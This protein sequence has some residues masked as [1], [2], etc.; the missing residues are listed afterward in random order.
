MN[1]SNYLM[2]LMLVNP[3]AKAPKVM[4]TGFLE[5]SIGGIGAV[6]NRSE[7]E[8]FSDAAMEFQESGFG[9]GRQDSMDNAKDLL[10][11]AISFKDCEDTG[12]FFYET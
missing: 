6:S 9:F 11:P 10:T 1:Y 8:V 7:D 12:K 5:K 2:Y 4:E 3:V